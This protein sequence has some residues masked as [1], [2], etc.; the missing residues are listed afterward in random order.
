MGNNNCI[1][2]RVTKDGLFQTISSSIWWS[3]STDSLIIH[4]KRE[5]A[6]QLPFHAQCKPP[7]H[8]KIVEE[9]TKQATLPPKPKEGATEPSEIV[10]KVKEE[11]KPGPAS[12]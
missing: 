8:L 1:G 12:K 3:P 11:I 6:E 9:E 7:K 5:N 4:S 10:M 2:S